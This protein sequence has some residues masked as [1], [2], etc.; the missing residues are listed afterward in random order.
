MLFLLVDTESYTELRSRGYGHIQTKKCVKTTMPGRCA[1]VCA[2]SAVR[3]KEKERTAP[4]RIMT[5]GILQSV[6]WPAGLVHF[7]QTA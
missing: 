2:C 4:E 5:Q 3:N 7:N 6:G 1:D